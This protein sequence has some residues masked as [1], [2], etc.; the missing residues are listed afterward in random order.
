MVLSFRPKKRGKG[1]A[2]FFIEQGNQKP[3]LQDVTCPLPGAFFCPGPMCLSELISTRFSIT[4]NK[5]VFH[6]M[7]A[8]ESKLK[9]QRIDQPAFGFQLRAS[10]FELRDEIGLRVRPALELLPGLPVRRKLSARASDIPSNECAGERSLSYQFRSPDR[11]IRTGFSISLCT[12]P[13]GVSIPSFIFSPRA[14][15]P[16]CD[17]FS[18][19]D[20]SRSIRI[21]PN[22]MA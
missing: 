11:A 5:K 17:C 13:T 4:K 1:H 15:I 2:S 18:R 9:A 16:G 6:G 22:S 21:F 14:H 8:K 19:K 10:S 12:S 3:W 20:L 7:T